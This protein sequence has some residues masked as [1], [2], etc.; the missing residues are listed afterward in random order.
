MTDEQKRAF[1]AGMYH[2][3]SWKNKVKRMSDAQVYAIWA[4]AQQKK[5]DKPDK[6]EQDDIPF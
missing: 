2:G 4:K 3:K 6:P 5:N 1:V